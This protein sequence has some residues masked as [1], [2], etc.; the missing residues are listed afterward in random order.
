MRPDA[1]RGHGAFRCGCGARVTVQATGQ[2]RCAGYHDGQPCRSAPAPDVPVDLC[3]EHVAQLARALAGK[4]LL[5]Q[6]EDLD[7]EIAR[8]L[9][10][11]EDRLPA[12][13]ATTGAPC[14]YYMRF[15]DRV[16]IGTTTNL[17][18]RLEVIQHDEL[19]ATEPGSFAVERERHR[20]FAALR[21]TGEWFRYTGALAGHIASLRNL[22]ETGR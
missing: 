16:K 14:V 9:H 2:P 5:A 6:D 1:L 20:R 10:A 12:H 19:L 3:R 4:V 15:G 8:T 17:A 11:W 18:L 22:A 21:V 7:E 13:R